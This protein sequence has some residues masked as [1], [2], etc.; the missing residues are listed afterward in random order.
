[1]AGPSPDRPLN[2]PE[3]LSRVRRLR[4]AVAADPRALAQTAARP[5]A[6]EA[7][8]L[9]S[10]VLPLLEACRFLETQAARLLAER[11]PAGSRPIWLFGTRLVVRRVPL[12]RVLVV[13]P[14]NY[15]L[16]LPGVQAI[17]A[18]VAG[19]AVFVKPAPGCAAPMLALADLLADE[20]L[21]VLDD[22][23]DAAR[24]RIGLGVEHVVLTGSATT[25]RAVLA[26][27]APRLVGATMELSG[28]D[29]LLVLPGADLALAA[30]A[31][32]FGLRF[33][34]GRTC[35]APRRVVVVGA[36][37]AKRL[38]PLVALALGDAVVPV[39]AALMSEVREILA[40]GGA[41]PIGN[42]A[43]VAADAMPPL[44]LPAEPDAAWTTRDLFAPLASM[45]VVADVEAAVALANSGLYALGAA[46]FGPRKD[47]MAVAREM[48]AGCVLVN[49][50]V[51]P[52]ADPRLPFGGTGDSG[53]GTT[54]GAEG[55]LAMTRPQAI[56]ARTGGGSRHLTTL[57]SDAAPLVARL[58]R[59]AHG[60]VADR[61]AALRR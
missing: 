5:G 11:T 24:E 14:A 49:D 10:E 56:V 21:S 53:F 17:Q 1:M 15:P 8:V 45:H 44:L 13:G 26:E 39:P 54:R 46:V 41:A 33:N 19:N 18:W 42:L 40:T 37:A 35:I 29:A 48:R 52:T 6:S 4:H 32:A 59:L 23:A 12:G 7:D 25:G 20:R 9:V 58:I 61:L 22:T 55:L 60:R 27:L 2:L 36:D 34:G 30:R 31:I 47:A 57:G 3:R 16:L 51:A 50:V 43:L 38:R 28:R